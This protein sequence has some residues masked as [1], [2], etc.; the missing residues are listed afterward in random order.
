M[1]QRIAIA[2]ALACAPKLLIADEPTTALDVT[3]QAG[4]LRLLDQLRREHGLAVVLITHDL[5][6]LSAIADR[7]S[8]FYAGRV[9]ESGS[10]E[11]VLQQPRHPYTR[12][13]LDALPHPEAAKEKPLVAI[14]GSPPSPGSI[15]PGVRSTHAAR[16]RATTAGSRFPRSSRRRATLRLPGRSLRRMRRPGVTRCS[17]VPRAS[18]VVRGRRSQCE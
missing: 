6:V 18:L 7:V 10:R 5:G 2:I 17:R 8:I 3:V 4:I 14:A 1:R 13:L 12:A 16:S 15:P 9:V 11:D